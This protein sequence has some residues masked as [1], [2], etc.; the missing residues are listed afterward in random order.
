MGELHL[1]GAEPAACPFL[2]LFRGG[3]RPIPWSQTPKEG[4]CSGFLKQASHCSGGSEK[5]KLSQ[6]GGGPHTPNLEINH[7][8]KQPL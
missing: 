3:L 8:K 2:Q 5:K 1:Q 7:L 6:D 4:V